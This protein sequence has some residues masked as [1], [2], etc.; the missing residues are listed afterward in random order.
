MNPLRAKT[1]LAVLLIVGGAALA[2][3]GSVFA[4]AVVSPP[5][6]VSK[7]GQF[8]TLAVPTEKANAATTKVELTL[9]SGFSIDSFA[10]APG[11]K[12]DAQTTGTGANTVIQKVTWSGG[13]V[14]T[15]EDAVFQFLA[16]T[17]AAKTYAFTVRQTYSD[18][19]VVDWSGP[20]SADTPAPTIEAKSSLGGGGSK[21][22]GI[23]ALALAV[24]ALV[25]A[26]AGLIG[27]SGGRTLA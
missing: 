27:K 3:A 14:P 20:E 7:K 4:H 8:F 2:L 11:W 22:L 25:V 15:E 10:P 5:V 18:G 16:S 24:L 1:R 19:S 21:T 23:V 13:N 17:D 26:V 6:V 9:P 12:R